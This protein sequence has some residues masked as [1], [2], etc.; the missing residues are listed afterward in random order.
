VSIPRPHGRKEVR[1]FRAIAGVV[2]GYAVMFV[3]VFGSFTA[4]YL[5]MGT[6]RAFKPG[7]YDVSM[8]W[9]VAS[10][11]LGLAAAVAGGLTCAIIAQRGSRAPVVLAA[12]LLVLGLAMAVPSLKAGG[13]EPQEPRTAAV[14]NFEAMANAK[15]P[16]FA[17][18]LNPFVGAAGVLL[19]ARLRR[20]PGRASA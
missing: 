17:A 3:V 11:V 18:V 7:S 12:L 16:A 5:A 13:T 20:G 6:D 2:V 14:G 15:T 8:T 19:G 1:V 4:A 10:I 9:L